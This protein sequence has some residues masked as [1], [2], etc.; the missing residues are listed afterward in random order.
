M[1]LLIGQLWS[2]CYNMV[3]G[4]VI[5]LALET[6]FCPEVFQEYSLGCVRS[7]SILKKVEFAILQIPATVQSENHSLSLSLSHVDKHKKYFTSQNIVK[8][9]VVQ[10]ICGMVFMIC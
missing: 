4:S 5:L 3:K 7:C 1:K 10:K 2:I 8:I 6:Y 9:C